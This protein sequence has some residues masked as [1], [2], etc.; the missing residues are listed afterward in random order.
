MIKITRRRKLHS[1][2]AG[3]SG[4]STDDKDEMVR[5]AAGRAES[6]HFFSQEFF[7]TRGIEESFCFLIKRSFVCR[8]ASLGDEQK[9]IFHPFG[10][11]E[12]DLRRK[13]CPRVDFVVHVQ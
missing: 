11:H 9:L 7:Q 13:I 8:S 2:E 12:V 5:R 10:G 3:L 6:L 1:L 4:S